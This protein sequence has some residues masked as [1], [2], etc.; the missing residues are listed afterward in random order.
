MLWHKI[1]GAGGF[2]PEAAVFLN[3]VSID[4]GVYA[5]NNSNSPNIITV[6]AEIA[7]TFHIWGASGGT[8]SYSSGVFSGAGGFVKGTVT[9]VPA[10]TYYLYI[11]AGGGPVEGGRDGNGGLGGWPNGGDGAEGDA[12]GGGGG[13]MSML[14]KA[15]YSV[16]MSN[17]DILLIA[18]GGGGATGYAGSA[19]AGGGTAGQN[20][21]SSPI[22]GGTQTTGGIHNGSKL[23]GGK[24]AGPRTVR[25]GNDGGGGGGG[26]YGGGGGEGDAKPG[27]GGSGYVNASLASNTLLLVGSYQT[28]P[29]PTGRLLT[30]YASGLSTSSNKTGLPGLAYIEF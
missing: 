12:S 29:N 22:T 10:T 4:S 20:G 17:A 5:Y 2:R 27:A 6:T 24:A 7:V 19:G 26:F 25:S 30:G 23:L 28:P 1:I 8:G 14:S 3:G 11:G 9:L 21:G 16:S 15:V 13:G 18:G